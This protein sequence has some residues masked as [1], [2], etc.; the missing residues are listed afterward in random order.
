MRPDHRPGRPKKKARYLKK[1]SIHR[2]NIILDV[3]AW[4]S[5]AVLIAVWRRMIK[6]EQFTI[7]V[8]LAILRPIIIVFDVGFW[9]S[10]PAI[11]ERKYTFWK[12]ASE[13]P[14]TTKPRKLNLNCSAS[15]EMFLSRYEHWPNTD[16]HSMVST[17]HIGFFEPEETMH[18]CKEHNAQL[19]NGGTTWPSK[20]TTHL[21]ATSNMKRLGRHLIDAEE[22]CDE[23]GLLKRPHL[24]QDDLAPT[25]TRLY[26]MKNTFDRIV[27]ACVLAA[28]A[29]LLIAIYAAVTC[30][31]NEKPTI[32][33]RRKTWHGKS[34]STSHFVTGMDHN[35]GQHKTRLNRV[36]ARIDVVNFIY[37]CGLSGFPQLV[38]VVRG[39][40][41]LVGPNPSRA[42]ISQTDS[43]G[44][45]IVSELAVR[46]H[47]QPGFLDFAFSQSD[48]GREPTF[49]SAGKRNRLNVAY[50]MTMT[51]WFDA[52]CVARTF[53]LLIQRPA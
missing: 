38:D 5:L 13:T 50:L 21:K 31:M 29:P 14:D 40:L 51:P 23:A 2:I 35:V 18:A 25:N 12:S 46:Y 8:L 37:R 9:R 22:T 10:M 1:A 30:Q 15:I 26:T 16:V 47:V 41:S 43:A 34:L 28:T 49:Q 39:D 42:T 7:L 48:F 20:A 45:I 52:K 24:T 27:A 36:F 44:E 6:S 3:A 32:K 53:A 17:A 11:S 19:T 33:L 4:L